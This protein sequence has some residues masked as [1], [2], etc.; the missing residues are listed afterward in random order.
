VSTLFTFRMRAYAAA[1]FAW[2]EVL[3][4]TWADAEAKLQSEYTGGDD[5]RAYP[6]TIHGEVRSPGESI[7]EAEPRLAGSISNTLS[8]IALAANAAVADPLPV[9]THGIDLSE[10]QPLIYYY[11]PPASAWF[12]PGKRLIDLDATAALMAAVGHHPEGSLLHRAMESYRR[13]LGYW[14]PET[15]LF[16]GE[17]LYIAAETLSRF[18]AESRAAQR[19]MSPKNLARLEKTSGEQALRQ[20]YL[21]DEIFSGDVAAF[22]AMQEASNGFEH[23]YMSVDD[24]RGLLGPVLGRSMG[25]VRRALISSTGMDD[26]AAKRLLDETFSKPRGLVPAVK[27]VRGQLSR[28]DPSQPAEP[29]GGAAVELEWHPSPLTATKSPDGNLELSFTDTATV[30]NLPPNVELELSGFGLRAAHVETTRPLHA[31]IS[32]TRAD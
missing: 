11:T 12:P 22:E 5:G 3:T 15:Q 29:M 6:V 28:R 8:L 19:G 21:R 27:M 30:I 16:A 7:E 10:P 4:V 32:I 13:A 18:L 26:T 20:R 1:H 17:F 31:D 25:H 23:G 14:I 24:V 2:D 9:A